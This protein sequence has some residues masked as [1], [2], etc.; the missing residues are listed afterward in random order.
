MNPGTVRLRRCSTF[1]IPKGSATP[2]YGLVSR[3]RGAAARFCAV[4]AG[5]HVAI[6]NAARTEYA[7]TPELEA[8]LTI[9]AKLPLRLL[10]LLLLV[11]ALGV[12]TCQALFHS[13]PPV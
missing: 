10:G 5:K 12:A 4:H 13:L 11:I 7:D 1:K 3:T 9:V 2:L 8:D 6:H